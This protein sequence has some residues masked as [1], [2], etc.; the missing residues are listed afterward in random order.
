MCLNELVGLVCPSPGRNFYQKWGKTFKN[1]I[2]DVSENIIS[3][4]KKKGKMAICGENTTKK[5][6]DVLVQCP[7]AS[8][9][10]AIRCR[11]AA[12]RYGE[13][14]MKVKIGT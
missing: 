13:Q 2:R 6:R 11:A 9:P 3:W 14:N 1:K 10:G 5:W 8:R 4:E 12:G 7:G